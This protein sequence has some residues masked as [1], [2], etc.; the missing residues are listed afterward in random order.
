MRQNKILTGLTAVLLAGGIAGSA[1]AKLKAEVYNDL[2]HTLT[3]HEGKREWV[4]DDATGKRLYPGQ[5]ADGNRTI[6]VGFNLE[7]EDAERKINALG[8]NYAAVKYGVKSLNE[9]QIQTL[10]N[11]DIDTAENDAR[12]YLGS[13]YF[14]QL[15]G[16]AQKVVVDMTFN[17][18]YGKIK[19]FGKMKRA[20]RDKNYARAA[21]CMEHSKWYGQ[22]GDRSKELVKI[23]KGCGR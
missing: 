7:R 13:R 19:Q 12:K 9:D 11:Q 18:G 5:M 17:M 22:V 4:Y 20:L 10:L 21:Y 16:N 3:R 8:L 2:S 6:A 14:D 1:D 15:E 23:M